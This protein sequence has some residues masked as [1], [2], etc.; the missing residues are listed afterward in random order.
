MK[1]KNIHVVSQYRLNEKS[2]SLNNDS[3]KKNL[4]SKYYHLEYY[5]CM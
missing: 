4:E 1:H 5:W 3:I 2:P